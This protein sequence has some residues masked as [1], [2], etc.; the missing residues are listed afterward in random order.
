MKYCSKCSKQISEYATFCPNCGGSQEQNTPII[1]DTRAYRIQDE[2]ANN[3]IKNVDK[4]KRISNL[5]KTPCFIIGFIVSLVGIFILSCSINALKCIRGTSILG[6]GVILY[7]HAIIESNINPIING[8]KISFALMLFG[9]ILLIVTP[10][11]A[12]RRQQAN[13][14][15]KIT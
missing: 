9:L 15:T 1:D 2:I 13:P 4:K 10:I 3:S 14:D 7:R 11:R 5:I 8:T 12:H 6:I